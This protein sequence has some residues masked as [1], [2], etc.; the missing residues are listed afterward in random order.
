[1][2]ENDIQLT[3]IWGKWWEP[4]RK[5]FYPI[6]LLYE[7]SIRFNDYALAVHQYI[8]VQQNYLGEITIQIF[9]VFF[10]I[11]TFIIC[12]SYLTVPTCLTLYKFFTKNDSTSTRFEQKTKKYF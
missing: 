3:S 12:T 9:A 2:E 4:I 11:V 10:G 8:M 6:W 5:W 7:L 1:M